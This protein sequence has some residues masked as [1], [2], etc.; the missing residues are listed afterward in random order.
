MSNENWN[1][2]GAADYVRLPGLYRS[3][4]LDRVIEPG[5]DFHVE[6]AGTASDGTPLLAV[7]RREPDAA[8]QGGDAP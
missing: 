1:A 3:W 4:E 7:Y 6:Q 8:E 2:S 5:A